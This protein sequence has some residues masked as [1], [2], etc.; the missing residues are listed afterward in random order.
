MKPNTRFTWSGGYA[1]AYQVVGDGARDLVYLS[2]WASN[3]DVSWDVPPIAR[4]LGRLA[5]F[6]RLILLDRRGLGCSDRYAP[7]A[8]PPLEECA[9]DVLAVMDAVDSRSATLFGVQDAALIAMMLAAS[10]PR[11][12]SSLVLFGAAA[13]WTRNEEMPW[14]R[15]AEEWD[16]EIAT[17]DEIPSAFERADT[18]VRELLPS[19]SGDPEIVTRIASLSLA[20]QPPGAWKAELERWRRVDVRDIL[21]SIQ[22]PT[23][24]LHRTGDEI[25]AIESGRHLA[26]RIPGARFVELDGADSQPWA[27]NVDA[28]LAEVETFV[29]GA[30]RRPT[31]D[32]P[33]EDRLLATLM[34]TDIVGSTE[35]AAELGDRAWRELLGR[36]HDAVR[37]QL[38]L[39]QGTEVETAGDGFLVRFDGPARGVRCA[40][41]IV[42]AVRALGIEIRAG[43]H[44][45][46]VELVGD[47]VEGIAVHT[48]ARVSALAG[49][50]E[51]LV[52]STV[53]DLVAGSGLTFE[54]VGEHDL[55]GVPDRWRL[56][57]VV[58]S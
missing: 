21:P 11:R 35:L 32:H 48:G 39:F 23:L 7:D 10:A 41:A 8:S 20:N 14:Q 51:V 4:F 34:F 57:R 50:S 3:V 1:I 52:S 40:R 24:V 17:S 6:S 42:E 43:L 53:K 45:G 5:S 16:E 46:E 58:S 19:L 33:P 37:E 54:D 36:H 31:S 26:R 49:P 28:V 56:Y 13:A 25:E 22:V 44:T 12:V 55:K 15:S 2:G 27:G 38:E 9:D 18:Y 47:K 30:P 29:T